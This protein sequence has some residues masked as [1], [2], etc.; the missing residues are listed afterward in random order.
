MKKISAYNNALVAD[1]RQQ[2]VELED[3]SMA[4]RSGDLYRLPA[5]AEISECPMD[6]ELSFLPG[7]TPIVWD[8]KLE[9]PVVLSGSPYSPAAAI[10]PIGYVRTLL[11]ASAP[12]DPRRATLPQWAY[13]A[14]GIQDGRTICA[15]VRIETSDR[16]DNRYFNTAELKE[17]IDK[18]LARDPQNRIL[19][20]LARCSQEYHCSTAQNIFYERWE[21]A[22]P[23]SPACNAKCVGCIS[24]Q[25][26]GRTPSSHERIRFAPNVEEI[27]ELSL[28]HLQ[29]APESILSFG[30]GCEG[31]PLL[32]A[33]RIAGAIRR[34]RAATPQGTININTNGSKPSRFRM[35]CESGLDSV[36]VSMNSARKET[37]EAY[38]LP[39]DYRFDDVVETL[40]VARTA[41]LAVSI[42]L[43]TFPGVTDREEEA[44]ALIALIR[45]SRLD[46][47]QWRNLAIDPDQ[48]MPVLPKRKG[49]ILGIPQ[50]MSLI[51]REVPNVHFLSFS[52]PKEYFLRQPYA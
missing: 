22:V 48:Y 20:Q 26:R 6:A 47:I 18:R 24:E 32:A 2:I 23:V 40:N 39:S 35:L 42:N 17:R 46:A 4:G 3:L 1:A 37:Y 30:Q 14:A 15:A 49:R 38:Y 44:E 8:R 41:G 9:R 28:H 50:L 5:P 29:N 21:A 16:W 43:L 10:L 12:V 45:R 19:Q 31:E 25:P 33:H 34:I 7:R 51:R 36:R 11:P 13:T 27:T 52:R